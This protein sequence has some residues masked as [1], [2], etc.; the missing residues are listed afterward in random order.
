[1]WDH[2]NSILRKI[3]ASP[4]FSSEFCRADGFAWLEREVAE[5]A[6]AQH[7][8]VYLTIA[9]NAAGSTDAFTY[10]D[11]WVR[12]IL[13]I[14]VRLPPKKCIGF[15]EDAK[16]F[17]TILQDQNKCRLQPRP[18]TDIPPNSETSI[19]MHKSRSFEDIQGRTRGV[20]GIQPERDRYD[21]VRS[22][23]LQ[24]W[25]DWRRRLKRLILGLEQGYIIDHEPQYFI[26]PDGF[27][28]RG[29]REYPRFERRVGAVE[30]EGGGIVEDDMYSEI[31]DEA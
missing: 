17:R 15:K 24:E 11:E 22:W 3:S 7:Y 4:W 23:S 18:T 19:Y 29:L 13:D 27:C 6:T 9:S 21:Y 20:E 12:C 26:D 5:K 30:A 8:Q 2:R 25:N 14:L 31:S 1:M 28:A 16:R 10:L